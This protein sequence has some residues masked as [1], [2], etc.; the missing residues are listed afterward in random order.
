MIPSCLLVYELVASYTAHESDYSRVPVPSTLSPCGRRVS[1]V[2]PWTV[3]PSEVSHHRTP[4]KRLCHPVYRHH[5]R[6]S[7]CPPSY[8]KLPGCL[9]KVSSTVE[10]DSEVPT[11]FSTL[12]LLH[13]PFPEDPWL[14][15]SF[16][17]GTN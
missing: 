14:V 1:Q 11:P 9:R 2:T 6:Q 4:T 3:Y 13:H 17:I 15:T 16:I 5:C 8:R 12:S 7:Y 10:L